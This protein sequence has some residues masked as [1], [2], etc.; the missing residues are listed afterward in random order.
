[1]TVKELINILSRF[2]PEAHVYL[3]ENQN[4]MTEDYVPEAI[5]LDEFMLK[6]YNWKNRFISHNPVI[7]EVVVIL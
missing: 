5:A 3:D 1:M 6:T 4:C 7:G 2:P